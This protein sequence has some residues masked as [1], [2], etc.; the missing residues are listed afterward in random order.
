MLI[1]ISKT[2]WIFFTRIKKT[3][4]KFVFSKLIFIFDIDLEPFL[5]VPAGKMQLKFVNL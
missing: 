4:K 3:L 2:V 5:I 1:S